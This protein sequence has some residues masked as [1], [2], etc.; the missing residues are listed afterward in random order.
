MSPTARIAAVTGAGG[1]MGRVVVGRLVADGVAAITSF[2]RE[3]AGF[4]SGEML[5]VSGGIRPHL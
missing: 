3:D 2:L 5:P 1:P 4:L